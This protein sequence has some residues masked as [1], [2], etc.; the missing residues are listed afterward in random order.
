MSG[1]SGQDLPDAS[2]LEKLAGMAKGFGGLAATSAVQGII[3]EQV[4]ALLNDHDPEELRQYII[5]NYPLVRE[6]LPAEYKRVI[7]NVGP[8]LA[9]QIEAAV[10]PEAIMTWLRDPEEWMDDDAPEE[11]LDQIRECARIIEETPEGERWL[12]AQVVE[13]YGLAGVL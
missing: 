8:S 9:G 3:R 11:H 6:E 2:R 4:V 13:I 7:S 5:V 12:Q 10:T 1:E